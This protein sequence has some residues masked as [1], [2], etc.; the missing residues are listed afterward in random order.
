MMMTAAMMDMNSKLSF[1]VIFFLSFGI[2]IK[3]YIFA[4]LTNN[5]R[6]KHDFAIYKLVQNNNSWLI[7]VKLWGYVLLEHMLS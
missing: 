6:H 7:Y 3:K 2:L 4:H 1:I 5:K